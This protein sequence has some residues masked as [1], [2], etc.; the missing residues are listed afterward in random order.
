MICAPLQPR[1][2]DMKIVEKQEGRRGEVWRQGGKA[3][4]KVV[5]GEQKRKKKK[6]KSKKSPEQEKKG[7]PGLTGLALVSSFV[8][9]QTNTE[10][11][12][13]GIDSNAHEKSAQENKTF[14]TCNQAV[15]TLV[16]VTKF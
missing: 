8:Q 2:Q 5:G 14:E 16:E 15:S 11:T 12:E 13:I 3:A 6:K 9:T 7:V 1:S 4:G 10:R